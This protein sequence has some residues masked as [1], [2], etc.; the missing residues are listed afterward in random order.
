MGRAERATLAAS[1]VVECAMR[2]LAGVCVSQREREMTVQR[3][4]YPAFATYVIEAATFVSLEHG[5]VLSME[6]FTVGTI[7]RGTRNHH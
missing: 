3:Q 5:I 2:S 7:D 6:R 1:L 4:D